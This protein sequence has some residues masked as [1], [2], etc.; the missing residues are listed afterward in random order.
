M[1][2][3]FLNLFLGLLFQFRIEISG[4]DV[5]PD[6]LGYYLIYRGLKTV[7]NGNKYFQLANRMIIP[8]MVLSLVNLYNFEKAPEVISS[9]IFPLDVL[10]IVVFAINMFL[11][12]NICKGSA[13]VAVSINDNSLKRNI[14]QRLYLYLVFSGLLCVISIMSLLPIAGIDSSL[15]GILNIAYFAYLIV[16]AL[17]VTT[18]H[19]VYRQLIPAKIKPVRA[20]ATVGGR[21]G[22]KSGA[23][24]GKAKR[25]R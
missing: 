14:I 12:Y 19:K 5:L 20:K 9:L 23:K 18:I 3:G 7:S 8:L 4:F 13:V 10:K 1:Y 11:I 17:I 15:Q 6:I 25:K 22:S 24:S 2:S 16:I 21:P